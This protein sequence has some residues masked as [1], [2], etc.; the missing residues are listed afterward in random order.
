[1]R[2]IV[3]RFCLE[4]RS[5]MSE[6]WVEAHD[7]NNDLSVI[8]RRCEV[9][10]NLNVRPEVAKHVNLIREAAHHMAETINRTSMSGRPRT[11]RTA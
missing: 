7:L 4:T 10:E 6:H 2:G 1:M 5:P 3:E 11:T 9:L 8:L